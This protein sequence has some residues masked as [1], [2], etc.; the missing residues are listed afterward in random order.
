MPNALKGKTFRTL[1]QVTASDGSIPTEIMMLPLGDW[2]T[3][4]YGPM[5]VTM[6]HLSQIVANFKSGVRKLVPVDVDHDGGK[7]AGWVKEVQAREDGLYGVI[8]WTKYGKDLLTEKI[9]RLFSPEW[10]FDYVDPEHGS[11]HGAV[12]IAGSLTNRPLFKELPVLMASE[13]SS[14]EKGLTNE[15]AIMIL[16]GSEESQDT[17]NLQDILAKPASKRTEEEVAFVREHISELTDEQKT[18]FDTDHPV[19]DGEGDGDGSDSGD[20]EGAGEGGDGEGEGSGEGEGEGSDDD[21]AGEGEGEGEGDGN[22]AGSEKTVTIKASEL[23]ELNKIKKAHE[24]AQTELRRI[25]TEKE[26]KKL[27]AN[28]QGGKLLPKFFKDGKLV[29]MV[30][31]FSESQKKSF[32]EFVNGLPEVKVAQEIGDGDGKVLTAKEKVDNLVSEAMKADENK[33]KNK[34]QIMKEVLSANEALA[35]EYQKELSSSK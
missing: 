9:Y 35:N 3:Q 27:M 4:Y 7:A 1:M 30:L 31:S 21:D 14:A 11:R 6:D 12:L 5:Q 22:K 28:E 34:A 2:N 15:K 13:G 29:D 24:K 33:G 17:M 23:A 18:Q 25:A 20:G 10:S 32:M 19:Q 26:L 8:E 16:L